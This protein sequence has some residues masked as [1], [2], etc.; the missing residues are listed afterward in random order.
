MEGDYRNKD[1]DIRTSNLPNRLKGTG[2]YAPLLPTPKASMDGT[3]PKTLEMAKNGEAEMSLVR[4]ME[5]GPS[6]F[7]T[8]EPSTEKPSEGQLSLPEDFLANHLASR[9][10]A[11]ARTTTA[12][13]GR[14][15]L[16]LFK[17][18]GPLG[19]LVRTLVGS[20]TWRSTTSALTWKVRA[21]RSGRLLF[22]LAPSG[23]LTDATEFGLLH[24]PTKEQAAHQTYSDWE[25]ENRGEYKL[26]AQIAV[27]GESM[28]L[29]TPSSTGT[30]GP[31]GLCGGSGN[32]KKFNKMWSQ[33]GTPTVDN[34]H[35][36]RTEDFQRGRTPTPAEAMAM[37][38]TPN[39]FMCHHGGSSLKAVER[40][41]MMGKEL[42]LDQHLQ[43]C[44]LPTPNAFDWNV[45]ETKKAWEKR[46]KHQEEENGVNLQL[47]LKSM[48]FHALNPP[49]TSGTSHG[50]KLQPVFVEWMMGYPL[51]F[52]NVARKGSRR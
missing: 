8:F 35:G 22:Q 52:T 12:T 49:E 11:E 10:S 17:R 20:S 15:C 30:G 43:L 23:R 48:I 34:F 3:S 6:Y 31:T 47:P 24:T 44:S 27:L 19:S 40:R 28:M 42:S 1:C 38:P 18:R 41:K 16:E 45:P 14:K 33:L 29:P 50:L 46:A 5:I 7:Q 4:M 21:T 32:R 25:R 9:G 26:H 37:L 36:H 2:K 13:S 39:T 51:G